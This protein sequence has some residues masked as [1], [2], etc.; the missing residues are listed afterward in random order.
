M[1][2]DSSEVVL[3]KARAFF[4]RAEEVAG[5]DNFDYAIDLYM[6]GLKLAPDALEDGHAPLRRLA[7]IRQAKGGKKPSVVEKVKHRG[8]KTPLEEMLNAEFLLAKDPDNLDYAETMLK[9]CVAGSYTRTADWIAQLIFDANRASEKPSLATYL[10]LKDSYAKMRMF[11]KAV[12]ACQHAVDLKPNDDALRDELRDLSASMTMEKGGYGQ[13]SDFRGSLRDRETQE[14]L[15]SQEQTVKSSR[16]R[17]NALED[18]RKRVREA[19]SITNIIQLAQAYID[20]DTPEGWKAAV[21]LL[22]ES[23][24]KT[25]DFSFKHKLGDFKIRKIKKELRLLH[26]T[27]QRHPDKQE[28]VSRFHELQKE[29]DKVELEH[30]RLCSENYPTDMKLK[31]EYGRCLIKNHRFDEAIPVFQESQ[32]DPRLRTLSLDKTGLCFLLKGWFDDAIDLFNEA[33]RSSPTKDS[34]TA[35]EIRYNLARACEAANRTAE[36]LEIYRKLAQL[37]F[38]YKDV[39]QRI[40]KLRTNGN[41][42]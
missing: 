27:I 3:N 12:V 6:E 28:L 39:S 4:S 14:K 40:D 34:P 25:K 26:E 38:S 23:Y 36:A 37:D 13:V 1:H 10:L 7:L 21:D 32:R 42:S 15:H 29:L 35:K 8:G 18:A 11:A 19:P 41:N 9:A 33:L 22:E 2:E 5:T 16:H 20:L 17:Q 24:N 31:Y 30:Y